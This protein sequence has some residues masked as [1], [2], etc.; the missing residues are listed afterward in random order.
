MN[1][2]DLSNGGQ[3][4]DTSSGNPAPRQSVRGVSRGKPRFQLDLRLG[5][6]S[7]HRVGAACK[8]SMLTEKPSFRRSRDAQQGGN[9][10]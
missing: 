3:G 7:G 2:V 10:D 5:L 8:P 4:V 9:Q 1:G 6:R